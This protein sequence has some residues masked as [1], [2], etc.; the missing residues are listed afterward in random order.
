M[1]NSVN[2]LFGF[3]VVVSNARASV[4]GLSSIRERLCNAFCTTFGFQSFSQNIYRQIK[5][6]NLFVPGIDNLSNYNTTEN[7]IYNTLD[8]A[9]PQES[10]ANKKVLALSVNAII[11][12]YYVYG[13]IDINDVIILIAHCLFNVASIVNN[14]QIF[15][16]D[17]KTGAI[18][19]SPFDENTISILLS[20]GNYN[21]VI[22]L[23]ASSVKNSP[24]EMVNYN[25]FEVANIF[26]NPNLQ[27]MKDIENQYYYLSGQLLYQADEFQ[28]PDCQSIPLIIQT[29]T[30]NIQ[31]LYFT[32]QP[33][34]DKSNYI[35]P[36]SG[37]SFYRIFN[38]GPFSSGDFNNQVKQEYINFDKA[39]LTP[40]DYQSNSKI[41]YSFITGDDGEYVPIS[42][43]SV[44]LDGNG[45]YNIPQEYSNI[46]DSYD[47]SKTYSGTMHIGDNSFRIICD[48]DILGNCSNC[49]PVFL[50]GFKFASLELDKNIWYKKYAYLKTNPPSNTDRILKR[51]LNI[52]PYSY[53][54]AIDDDD[55][56]FISIGS[57]GEECLG[58]PQMTGQNALPNIAFFQTFDSPTFNKKASL[59]MYPSIGTSYNGIGDNSNR[60]YEISPLLIFSGISPVSIPVNASGK[61]NVKFGVK[62]NSNFNISDNITKQF[63]GMGDAFGGQYNILKSFS[64]NAGYN[65][66][67]Y[68]ISGEGFL[69]NIISFNSQF[70]SNTIGSQIQNIKFISGYKDNIGNQYIVSKIYSQDDTGALVPYYY[71]NNQLLPEFLKVQETGLNSFSPL[72]ETFE[73]SGIY[74]KIIGSQKVENYLPRYS[75]GAFSNQTKTFLYPNA[76]TADLKYNSKNNGFPVKI[77]FNLNIREESVRELYAKFFI[78]NDGLI[79]NVP[80]KVNVLRASPNY[81][82]DFSV[83]SPLMNN[84]F[85]PNNAYYQKAFD[86]NNFSETDGFE[87]SAPLDMVDNNWSPAIRKDIFQDQNNNFVFILNS[88]SDNTSN[89]YYTPSGKNTS[90]YKDSSNPFYQGVR[91]TGNM[92]IIHR[93]FTGNSNINQY[94]AIY[95]ES[96]FSNGLFHY[97]RPFQIS[98][99]IEYTEP[100]FDLS[101]G[102][103]YL[104]DSIKEVF[105]LML[106]GNSNISQSDCNW[107]SNP[108]S[109]AQVVSSYY[110]EINGKTGLIPEGVD[111]IFL[112][113]MGGR[114]GGFMIQE[115]GGYHSQGIIG[116]L[117]NYFSYLRYGML[118]THQ[119]SICAP[120]TRE[121][122][123]DD[124]LVLIS[125]SPTN[126]NIFTRALKYNPFILKDYPFLPFTKSESYNYRIGSNAGNLSLNFS[127]DFATFDLKNYLSKKQTNSN[128]W[129]DS[130]GLVIGP[131]DRDIEIGVTNG[132]QIY[133]N[134][135]FYCNGNQLTD[136]SGFGGCDINAQIYAQ[137]QLDS[138]IFPGNYNRDANFTIL[139]IIPKYS[140]AYLNLSGLS[141]GYIGF[142]N[143]TGTNGI[144]ENGKISLR[145]RKVIGA[146]VYDSNIHQ[147]EVGWINP[148]M[149]LNNG[150]ENKFTFNTN[151]FENLSSQPF[152]V[153][154][155]SN[156]GKLY[157]R[158][159]NDFTGLGKFDK[160][161][162]LT[163]DSS[164]NVENYWKNYAIRNNQNIIVSGW[165]EGSRLSFEFKNIEI[166]YDAMPYQ[167]HKLIIP[168]GACIVT[169]EMAYLSQA[170]KSIYS[171]GVVLSDAT[172]LIPGITEDYTPSYISQVL[173]RLPF[174]AELSGN[175]NFLTAPSIMKERKVTPYISGN[176]QYNNLFNYPPYNYNKISWAATSDLELLNN[177]ETLEANLPDDPITFNNSQ[178]MFSASQGQ[179]LPNGNKNS[180]ID[181]VYDVSVAYQ[182]Y[183]SISTDSVINS[184]LCITQKRGGKVRIQQSQDLSGILAPLGVTLSLIKLGIN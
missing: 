117:W 5:S 171:A 153:T 76:Q 166:V 90:T 3:S 160:F 145:P 32:N 162:N 182:M 67:G 79:S 148:F 35:G 29:E 49:R 157:P 6:S 31:S 33:C 24:T 112:E 177:G 72:P 55:N 85:I 123:Y 121:P 61:N 77:K 109:C 58:Y 62:I 12:S 173:N 75:S 34:D 94:K 107:F 161:G 116:D 147:G 52:L 21:D 69:E 10:S 102:T 122:Y 183:D 47:C 23:L 128:D 115:E 18:L 180:I 159:F 16:Q 126:T 167:T 26:P 64:S 154:T 19:N 144:I 83:P 82:I 150:I 80:M 106:E 70:I 71:L 86:F 36:I 15:S 48:K 54:S 8:A 45:T 104:N 46:Q 81:D 100:Y 133:S 65:Y 93:I 184:G 127:G 99:E 134:A 66:T 11:F 113:Y 178:L 131:F 164:V 74:E 118:G 92:S 169:G 40:N 141:S 136:P 120:I 59:T 108:V 130:T 143:L 51:A 149:F 44:N 50:T 165:R 172:N 114:S 97:Y 91:L 146:S 28:L 89:D 152:I 7:Y 37:I 4:I 22:Q 41:L 155:Y 9:F 163:Y 138:G 39:I 101:S 1:I 88:S 42:F 124:S 125:S 142:E 87:Y 110:S 56:N 135:N 43:N 179:L 129:Y 175:E 119:F 14:N 103:T 63:F 84:I 170:E 68:V 140:Y 78:S 38:D 60:N 168:S 25:W 105:K 96:P 17:A 95:S 53:I 20:T 111:P 98:G 13:S 139:A 158:P 30:G 151:N 137:L 156:S 174:F 73:T 132:N 181:K 27:I 2:N 176:Q 57:N